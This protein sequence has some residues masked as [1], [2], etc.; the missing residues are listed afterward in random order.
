M[1]DCRL[2]KEELLRIS[3]VRDSLNEHLR[4]TKLQLYRREHKKLSIRL[5]SAYLQALRFSLKLIALKVRKKPMPA[6]AINDFVM[7]KVIPIEAEL[8][9]ARSRM[10]QIR[11]ER[12]GIDAKSHLDWWNDNDFEELSATGEGW[13]T[14]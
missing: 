8:S 10:L 6:E 14:T 12:L 3:R 7:G 13:W 2:R 1:E 9:G 11:A 4:R 5:T